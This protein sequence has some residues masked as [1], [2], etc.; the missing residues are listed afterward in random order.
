MIREGYDEVVGVVFPPKHHIYFFYDTF[1]CDLG[2]GDDVCSR[3]GFLGG[4]GETED[5]DGK[6]NSDRYALYA[7][8]EISLQ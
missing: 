5:V 1:R 3:D 4:E 7:A 6:E 2:V 8:W